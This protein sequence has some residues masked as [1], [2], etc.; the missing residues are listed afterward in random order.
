M[1]KEYIVYQT[2]DYSKA[3]FDT[4]FIKIV[5]TVF[6]RKLKTGFNFEFSLP[7][8]GLILKWFKI[9]S[10]IYDC[11]VPKYLLGAS[12]VTHVQWFRQ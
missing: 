2:V 9:V 4:S 1:P 10:L 5:K 6:C 12:L 3:Y 11:V 7:E 8:W